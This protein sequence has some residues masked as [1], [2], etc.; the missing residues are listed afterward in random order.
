MGVRFA[1]SKVRVILATRAAQLVR[2]A[3]GYG[4]CNAM[5][6]GDFDG[7]PKTQPV[8]AVSSADFGTESSRLPPPARM[9]SRAV[10]YNG[11]GKGRS[12]PRNP[13]GLPSKHLRGATHSSLRWGNRTERLEANVMEHGQPDLANS[14]CGMLLEMHNR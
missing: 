10:N 7:K 5:V 2:G 8:R 11:P 9:S 4:R 1:P 14:I 13:S 3:C 12:L 6:L